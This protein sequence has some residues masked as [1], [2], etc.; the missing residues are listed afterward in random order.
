MPTISVSSPANPRRQWLLQDRRRCPVRADGV[1]DLSNQDLFD[2]I[3]REPVNR[4][5]A[6]LDIARLERCRDVADIG[7]MLVATNHPHYVD[8]ETYSPDTADF[9]FRDGRRYASDTVVM[10]RTRGSDLASTWTGGTRQ[11]RYLLL[12]RVPTHVN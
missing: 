11:L 6:V 9:D 3:E 7:F 5:K 8:R 10:Y 12:L 4:H 2:Q 1:D